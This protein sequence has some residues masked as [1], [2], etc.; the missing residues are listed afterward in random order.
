M[1]IINMPKQGPVLFHGFRGL[2]DEPIEK[3]CVCCADVR[4][5]LVIF[6]DRR[7][8]MTFLDEH[9]YPR[10][11]LFMDKYFICRDCSKKY[12]CYRPDIDEIEHA[13]Y[14]AAQKKAKEQRCEVLECGDDQ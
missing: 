6:G 11:P 12:R 13:V 8:Q 3:I 5:E 10:A 14:D 4:A 2:P 1:R 7:N 9:E